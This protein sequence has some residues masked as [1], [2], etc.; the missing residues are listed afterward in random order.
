MT[1]VLILVASFCKYLVTY[2]C[3]TVFARS[4]DCMFCMNHISVFIFL[5]IVGV[6]CTF[7]TGGAA[8]KAGLH[9]GD[10][11]IK[12]F[13]LIFFISYL[14]VDTVYLYD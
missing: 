10:K 9:S 12:V 5:F 3:V 14:Q 13:T 8:E 4:V 11:I 7:F 6:F 2:L 1:F